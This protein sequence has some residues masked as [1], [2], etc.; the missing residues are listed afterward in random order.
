M[1]PPATFLFWKLETGNWKLPQGRD[2]MS[3]RAHCSILTAATL[4][5]LAAPAFAEGDAFILS[6]IPRGQTLYARADTLEALKESTNPTLLFNVDA[7]D[8]DTNEI[9]FLWTAKTPDG[10]RH[11][12]L[13]TVYSLQPARAN[14]SYVIFNPGNSSEINPRITT[15]VSSAGDANAP[16]L[17]RD[18]HPSLSALVASVHPQNGTLYQLTLDR[19]EGEQVQHR[20]R[21]L[22]VMHDPDHGWRFVGQLAGNLAA[23]SEAC[24]IYH[25]THTVKTAVTWTGV[26]EAPVRIA[27]TVAAEFSAYHFSPPSEVPLTKI[28]GTYNLVGTLPLRQANTSYHLTVK[29]GDTLSALAS[30]LVGWQSCKDLGLYDTPAMQRALLALN[31]KLTP[32]TLR[33]GD[34]LTIPDLYIPLDIAPRRAAAPAR[35]TTPS[36]SATTPLAADFP[37]PR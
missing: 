24:S 34:S 33:I 28:A 7:P 21:R 9:I 17:S 22:F 14:P 8:N 18:D 11:F 1:I 13:A 10:A 16:T 25:E 30:N 29:K 32:N 19:P 20:E 15:A 37:M 4:A 36:R 26:P 27:C 3:R 5:F 23:D 2:T 35:P 6:E 12:S 31:P